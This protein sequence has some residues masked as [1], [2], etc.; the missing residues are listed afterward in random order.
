MSGGIPSESEGMRS[1]AMLADPCRRK[2]CARRDVACNAVRSDVK[3]ADERIE[4]GHVRV[5]VEAGGNGLFG[6][7]RSPLLLSS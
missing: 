4:E 1:V 2:R 7:R 5:E 3:R 6:G